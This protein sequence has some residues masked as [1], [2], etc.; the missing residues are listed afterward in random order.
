LACAI[1]R[2]LPASFAG[3]GGAAGANAEGVAP[4]A[5]CAGAAAA[6]GGAADFGLLA[7]GAL[8]GL[9]A[10]LAGAEAGGA[11]SFFAGGSNGTGWIV[12]AGSGFRSGVALPAAIISCVL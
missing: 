12:P 3:A 2:S 10:A 11:A 8:D 1:A 6:F 9:P 5:A 4:D 7:A